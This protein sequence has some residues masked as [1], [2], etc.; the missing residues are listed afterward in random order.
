[1]IP[2]RLIVL[3]RLKED[4]LRK[5][6]DEYQKRLSRYCALETV[7]LEPCRLPDN[8]SQRE[9]QAVL[10]KEAE[11]ILAKI[12]EGAYVVSLCIEGKQLSSEE[13]AERIETCA[14]EGRRLVLVVGSS[15]GLDESVKRRADLRLSFSKMTFPHQLFRVLLLEQLYRAFQINSG[16]EYHK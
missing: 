9:K 14:A 15:F 3:G 13:W 5:A 11:K 12:P 2:V 10:A 16:G 8:P 4:Y 1:M 7:E 6:V